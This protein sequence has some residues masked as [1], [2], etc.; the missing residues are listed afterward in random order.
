MELGWYLKYRFMYDLGQV[1]RLWALSDLT[2]TD[3]LVDR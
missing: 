2:Q 3:I 1:E